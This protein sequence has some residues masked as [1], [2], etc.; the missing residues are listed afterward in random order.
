MRL[1]RIG[2]LLA[3]W[4]PFGFATYMAWTPID[5]LG[6]AH[7]NDKV[8]HLLTFGYLTGAFAAAY[9]RWTTWPRT[10]GIMFAYAGLIEVVQAFIPH[11]SCSWLDMV[12]D[13]IGI[14]LALSGLYAI[15]RVAGPLQ[16]EVDTSKRAS[17]DSL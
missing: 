5:Y 4:L 2:L 16:Q 7:I 11:R 12:A 15:K 3:F 1:I 10:T 9:T 17:A 13:G 8:V 14:F 6:T